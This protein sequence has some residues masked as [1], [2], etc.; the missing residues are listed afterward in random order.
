MTFRAMIECLANNSIDMIIQHASLSGLWIHLYLC[1]SLFIVLS[2]FFRSYYNSIILIF[3][4]LE[5]L[6]EPLKFR[7]EKSRF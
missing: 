4:C 5:K 3:C 2:H 1:I 6:I 7:V